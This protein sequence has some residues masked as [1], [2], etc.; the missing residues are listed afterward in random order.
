M[1]D[2]EFIDLGLFPNVQK[3]SI[4]NIVVPLHCSLLMMILSGVSSPHI[5]EIHWDITCIVRTDSSDLKTLASILT[6]SQF[7]Q[8]QQIKVFHSMWCISSDDLMQQHSQWQNFQ[9]KVAEIIPDGITI[10][11]SSEDRS[12]SGLTQNNLWP[13][14]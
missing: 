8:L 10:I 13:A 6:R 9:D 2:S 1:A 5:Q 14:S 12:L 7:P 3:F 11:F 4:S